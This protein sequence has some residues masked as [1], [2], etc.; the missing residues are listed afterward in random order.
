MAAHRVEVDHLSA[1]D[2]EAAVARAVTAAVAPV[3]A[4]SR[5]L[6]R[7]LRAQAGVYDGAALA[8]LLGVAPQTLRKWRRQHGLPCRRVGG[9]GGTALYLLVEVRAW[10]E[11]MPPDSYTDAPKHLP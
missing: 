3:E 10:L 2:L 8:D 6:R 7:A 9:P 11:R 1:A 5:E 4:A